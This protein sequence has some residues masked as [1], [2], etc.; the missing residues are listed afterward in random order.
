MTIAIVFMAILGVLNGVPAIY[1]R[2]KQPNWA[3]AQAFLSGGCFTC[4][5][6]MLVHQYVKLT[7]SHLACS[8]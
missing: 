8:V 1:N 2:R 4:A 7:A 6:W 5:Y 3:I